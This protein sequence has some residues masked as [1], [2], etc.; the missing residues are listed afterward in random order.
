MAINRPDPWLRG[1]ITGIS[2]LLQ[3]VA[4]ALVGAQEDIEAAVLELSTDQWWRRVG[5]SASV[6]FHLV[7]LA[8]STDRLFTYARG[9]PLT[10]LQ[11]E[12]LT[13]EGRADEERR[14]A[15]D[16]FREWGDVVQASLQQLQSTSD[17]S[18]TEQR[19]VGRAQLGSNV[20]GLLFHA[21]E[22]VARHT[23]QIVTTAKILRALS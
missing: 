18:L 10:A 3:P 14:A 9:E 23:G 17:A 15:G 8:G 2:P 21:A 16:L 22:H 20:L 1:P 7:H 12:A 4:H 13:L 19:L 6:G 11:R 5:G